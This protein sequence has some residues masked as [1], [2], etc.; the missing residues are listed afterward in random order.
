ML[1][2]RCQRHSKHLL[3]AR[4]AAVEPETHGVAR[5]RHYRRA[6]RAAALLSSLLGLMQLRLVRQR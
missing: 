5:P 1:H 4:A 6:Q 3:D 2:L